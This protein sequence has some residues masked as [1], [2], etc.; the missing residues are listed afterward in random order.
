MKK[1][2]TQYLLAT[3][4]TFFRPKNLGSLMRFGFPGDGWYGIIKALCE[5]LA[6]MDLGP[7][8]EVVQVKEKFGTLRFYVQG[9]TE[10]NWEKARAR[11]TQAEQAS[12]RTCERCGEPG[13][14]GTRQAWILTLCRRCRAQ[15]ARIRTPEDAWKWW[16]EDDR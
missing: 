6:A 4:P 15:K 2:H 7:E 8:F 5:D 3:Y 16:G 9:V 1:E 14:I 13:K 12:A 11:I 10:A